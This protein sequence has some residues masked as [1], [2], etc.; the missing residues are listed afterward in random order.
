MWLSAVGKTR[1]FQQY[2]FIH[3]E[4]IDLFAAAGYD[5]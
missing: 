5:L 3:H 4:A 2:E 1:C